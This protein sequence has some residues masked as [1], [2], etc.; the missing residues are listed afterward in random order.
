VRT[1]LA[2]QFKNDTAQRDR[3]IE[4]FEQLLAS[5]DAGEAEVSA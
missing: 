1:H 2:E 4:A 5:E 3:L